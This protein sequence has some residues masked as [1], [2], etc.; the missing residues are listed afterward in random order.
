MPYEVISTR[1]GFKYTS[2]V[3]RNRLAYT[4]IKDLVC[5][6][7]N[8]SEL[9][10]IV[11]GSH[12]NPMMIVK[13]EDFTKMVSLHAG[14]DMIYDSMHLHNNSRIYFHT[15]WSVAQNNWQLMAE[16]LKKHGINIKTIMG[17][18]SPITFKDKTP[19]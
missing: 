5:L 8:L 18:D 1:D 13:E 2:I 10:Q 6:K 12:L 3:P 19:V 7:L 16:Q 11:K 9:Q 15:N 14:L 4:I 17:E